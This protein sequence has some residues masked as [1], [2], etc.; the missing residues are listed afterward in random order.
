MNL[1]PISNRIGY[2]EIKAKLKPLSPHPF[3]LPSSAPESST[4]SPLSSA[5]GWGMG[6]A[7]SP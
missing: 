7:V 2:R 1:L 4:S 3:L 6:V 5:G